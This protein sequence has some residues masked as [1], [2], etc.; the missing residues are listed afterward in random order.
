MI[1]LKIRPVH[2]NDAEAIHEIRIQ[3]SVA[4][5]TLAVPSERVKT[6][7][8]FMNSMNHD[9]H[10][11]VAEIEDKVVGMAGLHVKPGKQRH[12]AVVGISIHADYHGKGVGS[13]LMDSL[14]DIADNYLGLI[15]LELEVSVSNKK[16][17]K[18]Y[19]K[20]GFQVEGQLKKA[21]FYA[22]EYHDV[23]IMGRV[24]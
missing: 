24:K 11:M 19:E 20:K 4:R 12:I 7:S 17:M 1:D 2:P 23:F 18:L 10:L 8:E 6:P 3:P 5:H 13:A 21:H 22:G 16:A 14:L 15:R 9:T